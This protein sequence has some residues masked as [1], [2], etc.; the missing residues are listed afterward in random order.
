MEIWH[1]SAPLYL[2]LQSHSTLGCNACMDPTRTR[3]YPNTFWIFPCCAKGWWCPLIYRRRGEVH[4]NEGLDPQ[5]QFAQLIQGWVS[6]STEP[7]V[8]HQR[9]QEAPTARDGTR[10]RELS[11]LICSTDSWEPPARNRE[12]SSTCKS[13]PLLNWGEG[14]TNNK[15]IIPHK[16]QWA[17]K[18]SRW[19]MSKTPTPSKYC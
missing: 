15:P 18:P 2:P 11:W 9:L 16:F 19:S 5:E 4:R 10:V 6:P 13:P 14:E 17:L 1:L 7:S 12:L 3:P 8:Q